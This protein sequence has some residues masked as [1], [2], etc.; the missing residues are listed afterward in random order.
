[1]LLAPPLGLFPSF[2]HYQETLSWNEPGQ[3]EEIRAL[4]AAIEEQVPKGAPVAADEVTATA[5]LAATDRP[6]LVQPKYEWT[7]ARQRLEE[8]RNVATRGTPQQLADFLRAHRCRHVA[9][10]WLKLWGTRYQVGL[11]DDI[12]VMSAETALA[13]ITRDPEH[14]PG[15]KLL[16]K[17]PFAA[18]RL[19]LLELSE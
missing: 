13:M 11:A 15:F 9:I 3:R 18:D 8:F 2:L 6:M 14:V 16:W 5:I 1:V 7:A 19:R 10:D 12:Q 17:S 4:V